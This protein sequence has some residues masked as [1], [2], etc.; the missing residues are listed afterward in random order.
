M[1]ENARSSSNLLQTARSAA[2][3]LPLYVRCWPTGV[4][5]PPT[6]DPAARLFADPRVS[7]MTASL[8]DRS[9]PPGK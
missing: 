4:G 6:T 5:A 1:P 2:F 3:R 8:A 7:N 9:S